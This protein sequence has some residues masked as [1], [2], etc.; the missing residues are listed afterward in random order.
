MDISLSQV[1][2]L[3]VYSVELSKKF[4]HNQLLIKKYN[5]IDNL[6]IFNIAIGDG[7]EIKYRDYLSNTKIKSITLSNFLSQNV[8]IDEKIFLKIDING[9]ENIVWMI[10]LKYQINII[11]RIL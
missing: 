8:E 1:N 9:F 11:Y 6:E 10:S 4:Y 2:I 3:K 5:N 7:S